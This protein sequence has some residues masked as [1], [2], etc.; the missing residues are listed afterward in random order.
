MI[1][2]SHKCIFVHIPKTGGTSL[3]DIVWPRHKRVE[4][5]LWMGFVDDYHNKY[6][7]GGLQ[8]LRATQIRQ[9]VGD[10]VFEEFYKFAIVR[11][12]WDKAVSQYAFMKKRQDLRDF[13]G[14]KEGDTFKA[15]LSLI[16]KRAHVQWMPQRDFLY[17]DSGRL[18]VDFVGRFESFDDDVRGILA[19]LGIGGIEIPHM[20]KSMRRDLSNYYDD[21]ALEV[22]RSLYQADIET[23]GYRR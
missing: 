14:M 6:Q 5:D 10:A 1:S 17:D 23:F 21:E 19:H 3:S 22:V 4:S 12:P 9:E 13:I 8:H 7:T 18:M 16:Q 2:Y 20:N 11:D 15:Y